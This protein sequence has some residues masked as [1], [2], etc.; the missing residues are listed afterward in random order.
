M[1]VGGDDEQSFEA[2]LLDEPWE[3]KVDTQ[4]LFASARPDANDV[5]EYCYTS[6]TSGQP[7]AVMHTSNTLMCK[8]LLARELFEFGR[9]DVIFMGSPLA[10]AQT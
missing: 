5:I 9:D 2:R 1:V 10:S 8:A 6:G 3:D 4:A 7:K